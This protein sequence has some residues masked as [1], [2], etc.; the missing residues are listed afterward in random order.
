M[1]TI[2]AI[3]AL[4]IGTAA[5]ASGAE[6]ERLTEELTTRA[7]NGQWAGAERAFAELEQVA[8][9]TP[10]SWWT[11]AQAAANLGDA[12]TAYR[13]VLFAERARL[14]VTDGAFYG[15]LE[16]YGRVAI[17]R[18]DATCIQ[19]EAIDPPFDPLKTAAIAFAA[20]ELARTGGFHGLLPAGAYRVG[21]YDIDV[22]GGP[23]ETIVARTRGDGE[24]R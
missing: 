2:Q 5:L 23:G 10:E 22:A 13:R 8:E 11:G 14:G 20:D 4:T 19:L 9:P 16:Q 24:C 15:Y 21:P 12:G 6:V 17:R 18:Q 7:R 3:L 1:R